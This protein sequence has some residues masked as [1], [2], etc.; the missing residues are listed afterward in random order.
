M[1]GLAA[2]A[3]SF[4]VFL[5]YAWPKWF[6]K[7]S[8][9]HATQPGPV[10]AEPAPP[11]PVTPS[12]APRAAEADQPP[13]APATDPDSTQTLPAE[14]VGPVQPPA[15]M[16]KLATAFLAEDT[17]AVQALLGS[18]IL[19]ESSRSRLG[20]LFR[21]HQLDAGNAVSQLGSQPALQRWALFLKIEPSSGQPPTHP[22]SVEVDFVRDA[23]GQWWPGAL[24]LPGDRPDVA[25][26]SPTA[27]PEALTTARSVATAL[28]AG[29][30]TDLMPHLDPERFSPAQATGLAIML[31]EGGFSLKPDAEPVITL[32]S[33]TQV[34]LMMPVVSQAWQT[35][36]QFGLILR[37][38]SAGH[39]WLVAAF[40][41]ESLLAVTANR[42]GAGDAATSLIRTPGQPDALCLYFPPNSALAD[43]RARRVLALAAAMLQ[44]DPTLRARL[45]G[46]ADA[47]EKDGFDHGL[48][49]AR[50]ETAAESLIA[51]GIPPEIL[52]RETHG[53]Q[54]PRRANFLPDGH[55]DPRALLLN[56]RVELIFQR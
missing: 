24:T 26:A 36:S 11:T 7:E 17:A 52:D 22:L 3:S 41:P 12:P 30:M 9:A 49:R 14:V 25:P 23:R 8:V 38:N 1:I 13:A 19:P 27:E 5:G 45:L 53:S 21:S 2:L 16:E 50:V 15:V 4:A 56:R 42:L 39:P 44:A 54:R 47:T 34:W 29:A 28:L 37:K 6:P 31:Q 55:P 32:A 33:P 40:N 43:E 46:H 51:A 35:E 10:A 18:R 48:T 20:E